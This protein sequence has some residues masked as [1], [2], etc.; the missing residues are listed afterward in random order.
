MGLHVVSTMG[1]A[2]TPSNPESLAFLFQAQPG[3]I[4]IPGEQF[5][6]DLRDLCCA[7]SSRKPLLCN[8]KRFELP[9]LDLVFLAPYRHFRRRARGRR[10]ERGFS[11]PS[12]AAHKPAPAGPSHAPRKSRRRLVSIAPEEHPRAARIIAVA[13]RAEC[14][15]R[16]IH[17]DSNP[18]KQRH[19]E[20]S[21]RNRVTHIKT[22]GR[23]HPQGT[24]PIA[25]SG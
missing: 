10:G 22:L 3:Q 21:R 4:R 11:R 1:S 25:I 15:D 9:L 23:S 17:A 14:S 20:V 7:V 19:A 8:S 2:A 13:I 16:I 18:R 24:P 6:F 12:V 5:C